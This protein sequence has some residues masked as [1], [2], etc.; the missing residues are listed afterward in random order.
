MWQVT[1]QLYQNI[2]RLTYNKRYA[3]FNKLNNKYIHF[4]PFKNVGAFTVGCIN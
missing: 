2:F 3:D 4:N 1:A